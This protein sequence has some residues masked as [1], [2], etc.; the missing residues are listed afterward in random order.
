MRHLFTSV[1]LRFRHSRRL[2]VLLLAGLATSVGCNSTEQPF[3]PGFTAQQT[4]FPRGIELSNKSAQQIAQDFEVARGKLRQSAI[5]CQEWSGT[6][7]RPSVSFIRAGGSYSSGI[8][9]DGGAL[10]FV[11]AWVRYSDRNSHVRV[12]C[13]LPVSI[14]KEHYFRE[15]SSE[16]RSRGTVDFR[17]H[18]LVNRRRSIVSSSLLTELDDQ[19]RFK[20]TES[21]LEFLGFSLSECAP[22]TPPSGGCTSL[23]VVITWANPWVGGGSGF[24]D[25]GYGGPENPG[26][27]VDPEEILLSSDDPDYCGDGSCTPNPMPCETAQMSAFENEAIDS[28]QSMR[29]A[30]CNAS[31]ANT[32]RVCVAFWIET[33][34]TFFGQL[35]GDCP[36]GNPAVDA[37][38][39]RAQFIADLS[40][41]SLVHYSV[42]PT[43]W[44]DGGCIPPYSGNIME[45][46]G[47]PSGNGV[48]VHGVLT[49][50][51]FPYGPSI[52][53]VITMS[54]ANGQV[55]P[56][57]QF[58]GDGYPTV[59]MWGGQN[60][61]W[62]MNGYLLKEGHFM[63]LFGTSDRS[64]NFVLPP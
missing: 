24:D 52:D 45:A 31:L 37:R 6:R 15:L 22:N 12:T 46:S 18:P 36:T 41:G 10:E 29:A 40:T 7:T 2:P 64:C 60:G 33:C 49:D 43:C 51:A 38:R 20:S 39:Y 11:S 5:G 16:R 44:V 13:L 3:E 55:L 48:R 34:T 1:Q 42:S 57:I 58:V 27:Y 25:S 63:S 19:K 30:F 50:S 56:T 62:N 8:R 21:R 53:F 17:K 28:I 35:R 4:K 23:P 32:N 14:N 59:G 26:D 9:D 54:R 47:I 61:A